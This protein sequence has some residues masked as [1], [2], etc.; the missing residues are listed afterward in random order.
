MTTT[1]LGEGVLNWFS[2]ERQC[3]RY[4]AVHLEAEP[5]EYIAFPAAEA[6]P[7]GTL[8]AVIVQTRPAAHIGDLFRGIG[9]SKPEPGERIELGTGKLFT[10]P[11]GSLPVVGVEPAD[12]R[13]TD[14]M[15]PAALYRCHNQRVRLEFEQAQD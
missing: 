1:V 9:P 7:T 12:G 5:G 10:Y 15:D 14:W 2:Y 13:D 6:G 3:D 11:E 4:G 8:F